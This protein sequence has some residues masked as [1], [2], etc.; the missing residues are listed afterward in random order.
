[1]NRNPLKDPQVGDA[2]R[3][4]VWTCEVTGRTRLHVDFHC[5]PNP[6][7]AEQPVGGNCSVKGWREWCKAQRA[8]VVVAIV[9]DSDPIPRP[10]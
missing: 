3:S 2:V 6:G 10:D 5:E 9:R 4:C 1:M 8:K 7:Q